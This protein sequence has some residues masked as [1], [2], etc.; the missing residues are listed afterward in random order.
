MVWTVLGSGG[1][2]GT[3]IAGGPS[4]I[5]SGGL[6]FAA[7]TTLQANG[8][9]F[10]VSNLSGSTGV[11]QNGS[12]SSASTLT[13]GSD[14]TSTSFGGTLVNGSSASL[15]LVKTGSGSLTLNSANTFSG[16][17]TVSGGTLQLGNGNALQNAPV[18]I[19]A[20][21][22]GVDGQNVSIPSLSG[23]GGAVSIGGGTLNI[24]SNTAITSFAG[25]INGS[26]TFLK[27]G[28]GSLTLGSMRA[29]SLR[30]VR[31]G[32][33]YLVLGNSSGSAL[34]SGT[35]TLNSGELASTSGGTVSGPVF[36]GNGR[37]DRISPGGDGGIGSLGVGGLTINSL[38][39]LRFDI[40]STSSFDQIN[41]TGALAFSGT[42]TVSLLVPNSVGAGLYPLM[43]YSST[44]S[45]GASNLSLGLIGGGT[46]PLNYQLLLTS[47]ALD[48]EIGGNSNNSVLAA[49]TTAVAFGRVMLNNVPTSNVAIS[50]SSGTSQTGFNVSANGG[51][52]ATPSGNGPG[53]IP[54]SGN[55]AI[56]LPNVTSSYSG[57]VSVQNSGDDG[58]GPGRR[59]PGLGVAPEPRSPSA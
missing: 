29:T 48:L 4:A 49:S 21:T 11:I 53:A 28:Q 7:N 54:P 30:S 44:S 17:A 41:D 18:T 13:V 51:I 23:S 46:V 10:G 2:T 16:G 31:L 8:Y 47:T 55:V 38:S 5:S 40:S 36:A 27:N 9:S 1:F 26:G 57:T 58:T 50:L 24:T 34:G 37:A 52:L 56:S 20:G 3:V 45:I 15:A 32:G 14:N 22:L 25:A 19:T 39:T 42:G 33:G 43:T 12:S 59:G 35:L 6:A